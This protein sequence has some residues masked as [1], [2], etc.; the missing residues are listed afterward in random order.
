MGEQNNRRSR[1]NR[2]RDEKEAEH[3]ASVVRQLLN[4]AVMPPGLDGDHDG[5]DQQTNGAMSSRARLLR[6]IVPQEAAGLDEPD[7]NPQ[8]LEC[9]EEYRQRLH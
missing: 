4:E 8:N 2:H 5:H 1:R 6:H 9:F 3:R 7:V